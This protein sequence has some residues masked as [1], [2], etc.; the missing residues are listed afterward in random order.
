[1]KSTAIN[2]GTMIAPDR[3]PQRAEIAIPSVALAVMKRP[4]LTR[5]GALAPRRA[6]RPLLQAPAA[7]AAAVHANT[8]AKIPEES[9]IWLMMT[10]GDPA[11][12]AKMTP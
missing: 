11:I 3:T 6:S 2:I 5:V 4:E 12:Y 8:P 1:M 7:S 10:T 9:P